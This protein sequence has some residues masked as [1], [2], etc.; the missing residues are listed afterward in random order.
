MINKNFLSNCLNYLPQ[1]LPFCCFSQ[2]VFSAML[3]SQLV[4]FEIHDQNDLHS[5]QLIYFLDDNCYSFQ[6][7]VV[8]HYGVM[9]FV[10]T[11]LYSKVNPAVTVHLLNLFLHVEQ[12]S[13]TRMY[14]FLLVSFGMSELLV[15]NK[16]NLASFLLSGFDSWG[17]FYLGQSSSQEFFEELVWV[18]LKL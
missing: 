10:V 7:V 1:C 18:E 11:M 15:T 13:Y 14:S 5:F 2:M 12:L 3:H 9:S 16:Q 8:D 17:F 6:C 4:S